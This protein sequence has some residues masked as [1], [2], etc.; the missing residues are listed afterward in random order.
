MTNRCAI[1]VPNEKELSVDEMMNEVQK[2][3]EKALEMLKSWADKNSIKLDDLKENSDEEYQRRQKNIANARTNETSKIA[4]DYR[5]FSMNF[6][7]ENRKKF[8]EFRKGIL[9]RQNLQLNK[10]NEIL[11]E[12]ELSLETL[13]RYELQLAGKISRAYIGFADHGDKADDPVQNDFNGSA[14]VSIILIEKSF[15]AWENI[16]K[17][18]PET[19]DDCFKALVMLDKIRKRLLADFPRALEFVRPCFDEPILEV[20]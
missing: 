4:A 16:M 10:D 6:R 2:N 20:N 15:H 12:F 7:S 1:F 11:N 14:K 18:F 13:S 9:E 17:N 5:I 19:E 8:D 3:F